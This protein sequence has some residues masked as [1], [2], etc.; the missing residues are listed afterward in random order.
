MALKSPN[1]L[2]VGKNGVSTLLICGILAP[3]AS[4]CLSGFSFPYCVAKVPQHI[5]FLQN[6]TMTE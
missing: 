6:Y 1:M 3:F 4:G 5:D 2:K